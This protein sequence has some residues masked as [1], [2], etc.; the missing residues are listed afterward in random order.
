MGARGRVTPAEKLHSALRDRT[1]SE[2][3][4]AWVLDLPVEMAAD[5][6]RQ[7]RI[8]PSVT[9]R[10]EAALEISAIDWYAAAG[11]PMPDFWQLKEQ[12]ASELA[13]IRRRRY[14]LSHDR[15]EEGP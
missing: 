8:T 4:L 1:W 12:M 6:V 5:L 9:L 13:A 14:R 15:Q 11:M 7:P 2:Q 3:E 10:L